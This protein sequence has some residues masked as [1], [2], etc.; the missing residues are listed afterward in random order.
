M[1]QLSLDAGRQGRVIIVVVVDI[2]S[3]RFR[4][5][6]V[7]VIVLSVV[8]VVV[9]AT[10]G[11]VR[12]RGVGLG[13]VSGE[14]GGRAVSLAATPRSRLRVRV[15]LTGWGLGVVGVSVRLIA[16]VGTELR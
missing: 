2:V 15:Y 16:G 12:R 1:T 5:I 8:G 14:T 10:F 6:A 4:L 9:I 13:G 3:F 11:R 7:V